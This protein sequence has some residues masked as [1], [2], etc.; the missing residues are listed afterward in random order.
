MA[1]GGSPVTSSPSRTI[2]PAV[3]RSTPVKQLK[4]V[5]LPAPF[6]PMTART[7]PGATAI[8]TRFSAVRPPNCTVSP[9]V[10]RIGGGAVPGLGP[11]TAPPAGAAGVRVGHAT[12]LRE[13][14]AG[15]DDRLLFGDDVHDLVLTA[16]ELEQELPCERLVILL[17]EELVALRKVLAFLH[18]EA[19]QGLDELHRVFA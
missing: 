10:W 19:L 9:S 6:G 14:A 2:R 8:D 16:A 12:G 18:L 15:W 5:D 3:G 4:N 13:L 7:S 17:A 1:C 11:D